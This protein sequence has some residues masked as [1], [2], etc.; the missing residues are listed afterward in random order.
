MADQEPTLQEQF[1]AALAE[2]KGMQR[3]FVL[4]YLHDLH[5]Q[6]A[7]IRA[8]YSDKTARSQASRMLTFVNIRRAIDA[9]LALQA[10]PQSEVLARLTAHGR[11]DMSDFLRTDEEDI[12]LTWS[13]L[14]VPM[15]EDGEPDIAGATIDLA[16]Q[17]NV[18][19]TDRVLHT[20]TVKRALSRLDLL[21]AGKRGKIGLI[22]KYTIDDKGKV[23][24]ELYDAQAAL[25]LLGKHHKL[26]T[27]KVEHTGADGQPLFKV[28]EKTDAFDP[29]D[30]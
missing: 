21:E 7:A 19:P 29:D 15:T 12:T 14:R 10:M 25:A 11:G 24:I 26:F 23:S 5:G 16:M 30:A 22:K 27:E 8:G 17:E 2:C 1:D 6:N 13:L 20:T 4:E 9:G 28:Y 3:A 18:K